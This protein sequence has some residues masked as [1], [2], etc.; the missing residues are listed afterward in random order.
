MSGFVISTLLRRYFDAFGALNYCGNIVE[1]A[2]ERRRNSG[3]GANLWPSDG[4]IFM[5]L[6]GIGIDTRMRLEGIG[7]GRGLNEHNRSL[8]RRL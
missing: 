3:H 8:C 4:L 1:P 6:I 5:N 2:A 7:E